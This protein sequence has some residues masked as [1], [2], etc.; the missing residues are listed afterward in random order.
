[1]TPSAIIMMVLTMGVVTG[2][3]VYFFIK[4]LR[5]PPKEGSDT[6]TQQKS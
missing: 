1:M 6:Y 4:V 3:A 5:T 2:F